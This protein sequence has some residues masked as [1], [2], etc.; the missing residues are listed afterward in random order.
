MHELSDT[1]VATADK[2]FITALCVVR[3]SNFSC[4]HL[5]SGAEGIPLKSF[6]FPSA[7]TTSK[8]LF[9]TE[10]TDFSLSSVQKSVSLPPVQSRAACAIFAAVGGLQNGEQM[11]SWFKYCLARG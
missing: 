10:W 5:K 3:K 11:C 8:P 6:I 4:Y 7:V 9:E 2:A 1:C